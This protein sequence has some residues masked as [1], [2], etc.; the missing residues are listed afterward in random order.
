M[1]V[2]INAQSLEQLVVALQ[3]VIVWLLMYHT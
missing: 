1:P 3:L 2:S